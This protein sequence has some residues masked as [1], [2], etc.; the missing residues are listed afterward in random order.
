MW[1]YHRR[2]LKTPLKIYITRN[3]E[4]DETKKRIDELRNTYIRIFYIQLNLI[5]SVYL[6][7]APKILQNHRRD[8]AG[9]EESSR[10]RI[11]ISFLRDRTDGDPIPSCLVAVKSPGNKH[12]I[13]PCLICS[14]Y[15]NSFF[16]FV[17]FYIIKYD[18]VLTSMEP[19]YYL[20][21][22]NSYSY[23]GH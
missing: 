21:R 2:R 5:M 11:Q 20:R 15:Y 19:V 14:N 17:F 6:E 18:A 22:T 1:N 23:Q 3:K 7:S 8:F 16:G 10:P 4:K 13:T 9:F 12:E